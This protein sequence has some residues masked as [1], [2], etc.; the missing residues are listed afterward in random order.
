MQCGWSVG[1]L[2]TGYWLGHVGAEAGLLMRLAAGLGC[3]KTLL[4]G[5]V[6]AE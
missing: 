2:G 3:A 6:G 1:A 5:H 4:E